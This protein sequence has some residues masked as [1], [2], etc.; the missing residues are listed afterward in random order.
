M[1]EHFSELFDRLISS[2]FYIKDS[3]NYG[4]RIDFIHRS[5]IE[6]LLAEFYLESCINEHISNINMSTLSLETISFFDGL[7]Y[8]IKSDS[9]DTD[10]YFDQITKSF[11]LEG[12]TKSEIRSTLIR[13][14]EK[15][16]EIEILPLAESIYYPQTKGVINYRNLQNHRWISIQLLNKLGDRYKINSERFFKFIRST[17]NSILGYIITIENLDLSHSKIEEGLGNYNLSRAKL[18]HSSFYGNF[19]GTIISGADLSDSLIKVGTRFIGVDFSGS[20]LTNLLAQNDRS[21][22]PFV[23]HFIDCIFNDC[24]MTNGVF[25]MTSFIL[26]KF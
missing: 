13:V 25:E 10:L 16:F 7:L 14:A 6:Y 15:N 2:Y 9:S 11:G 26:S 23:A 3:Y 21:T 4:K 22:S 12:K 5:F 17:N 20:N 18:S 24:N 8:L 19:F 1:R